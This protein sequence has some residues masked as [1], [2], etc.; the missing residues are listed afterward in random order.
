MRILLVNPN[1]Y[2]NPP[3]PPLGLEHLASA[4]EVAGHSAHILDLCFAANPVEQIARKVKDFEPQA[5]ALT[6]RNIDTCLYNNNVFFLDEIRD[7]ADE[8]KKHKVPVIAGGA[9]FSFSPR[10][11]L[12]YIGAQ[13]GVSGPGER[14]LVHLL[15]L[16]EKDS[17]PEGALIDGARFGADPD[18]DIRRPAEGV[19]YRAYLDREGIPGFETQKGCLG[20]CSYC[21]EGSGRV[22]HR[23]PQRVVGELESLTRLGCREFHLCDSE[24]NQD[25]DFC[26]RFLEE[27]IGAKLPITWTLYM[28]T[29]PYDEELFRLLKTSGADLITITVP[30]GPDSLHH[31]GIITRL[32][33][34]QK[35]RVAVDF[36]C[37]F[38][39]DTPAKVRDDIETL[40]RIR[41]D[42]VGVNSFIR[43][44][45]STPVTKEIL[46]SPRHRENVIGDV[47]KNPSL[48]RPVF[49]NS[50]PLETLQDLIGDDPLFRIEGF[51]RTTNY[52]RVKSSGKT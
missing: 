46:A 26:R 7:V 20:K 35:L 38:P 10:A 12:E 28:K 22:V 45:E 37:G 48:L 31:A 16:L 18:L 50:I 39:G 34:K 33:K 30:S 6:V 24:F 13:W 41:P 32:S 2:Q 4:L 44:A 25:L 29:T 17:P 52:Q 47:E 5:S 43:L 3:V 8:L 15:D 49:Y 11:I 51:E 23:N 42:T 9:G 19:D 36:L 1:R 14:A 21:P 40:R 27:L